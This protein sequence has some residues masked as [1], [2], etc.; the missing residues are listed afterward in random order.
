[1]Q[2]DTRPVIDPDRQNTNSVGSLIDA[3]KAGETIPEARSGI[4]FAR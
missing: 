1:M 3:F 4:T 2:P